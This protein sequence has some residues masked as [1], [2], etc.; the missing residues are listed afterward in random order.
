MSH[1]PFSRT[2]FVL[3]IL[4]SMKLCDETSVSMNLQNRETKTGIAFDES[5]FVFVFL[6][7]CGFQQQMKSYLLNYF[8]SSSVEFRNSVRLVLTFE[9][10]VYLNVELW[11][12]TWLINNRRNVQFS[13]WHWSNI[14]LSSD[15]WKFV[16]L[17][18]TFILVI[19]LLRFRCSRDNVEH[20]KK[21]KRKKNENKIITSLS[22]VVSQ[23]PKNTHRQTIVVIGFNRFRIFTNINC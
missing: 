18:V 13:K 23:W 15:V 16:F 14:V 5:W 21:L 17:Y 11:N 1:E 12:R 8:V 10:S 20:V 3:L 6:C 19:Y 22:P 7:V 4:Q 2:I 9:N